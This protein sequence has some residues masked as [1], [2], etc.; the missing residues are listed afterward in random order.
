MAEAQSQG[1]TLCLPPQEYVGRGEERRFPAAWKRLGSHPEFGA[2]P[3]ASQL[4][5]CTHCGAV[6]TANYDQYAADYSY[7]RLPEGNADALRRDAGPAALL[8]LGERTAFAHIA[9]KYFETVRS[10]ADALASALAAALDQAQGDDDRRLAFLTR[11][12]RRALPRASPPLAL[13][14]REAS[15]LVRAIERSGLFDAAR[16]VTPGSQRAYAI[17][18]ARA[19]IEML[20]KR[21]AGRIA[22]PEGR[23]GGP[24][25]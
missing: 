2:G 20:R 7:D 16:E 9:D 23:A 25:R 14:Q 22:G 15:R 4:W 19:V 1:C 24:G 3:W 18:D 5:Y 12:L 17:E 21:P 8:R 10:D 13:P 11:N 6:W